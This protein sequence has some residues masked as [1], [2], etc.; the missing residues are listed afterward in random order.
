[1]HTNTVSRWTEL[2]GYARAYL[3]LYVAIKDLAGAHI[4]P[5]KRA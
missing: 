5:R 1:M 4:G 2:P 3:T